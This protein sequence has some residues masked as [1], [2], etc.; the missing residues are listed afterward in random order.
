VDITG[1]LSESDDCSSERARAGKRQKYH[2]RSDPL[3]PLVA[4]L[5]D[6]FYSRLAPVANDWAGKLCLQTHYPC[7][8]S[9]FLSRCHGKGQNRSTPLILKYR[10]G[11]Y[12]RL[13]QDLYGEIAFPLQLA[14]CLSDPDGFKG[15][16]FV[17]TEQRPR[18]QTRAEVV[19]LAQGDGI[20]FANQYRPVRS[21]RGYARVNVRH[22]V[23]RIRSGERYCLG[24]IFHDAA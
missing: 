21:S 13:H 12:N 3:P 19:S 1:V 20:V 11:D 24:V 8:L 22:G 15:G 4:T 10:N 14:V 23:S 6:T 9:V 17:L 18:L 5:R 2:L 7:E 16:E